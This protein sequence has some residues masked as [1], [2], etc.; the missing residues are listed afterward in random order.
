M[1]GV[2]G[3]VSTSLETPREFENVSNLSNLFASQGFGGNAT[4]VFG[5]S[6][7][8]FETSSLF[9]SG[10][11]LN[12]LFASNAMGTTNFPNVSTQGSGFGYNATNAFGEASSSLE[13]S[14]V[15]GSGSNS[16]NL[17]ASNALGTT[18]FPNVSTQWSAYGGTT[19]NV[20]R[21]ASSSLG[22]S[23]LFGNG[24]NLSN[25]FAPNTTKTTSLPSQGLIFGGSTTNVL[26]STS[27]SLG[28]SSLF[29]KDS[30][31]NHMFAPN[32][33]GS[34]ASPSFINQGS[35]IGGKSTGVFGVSSASS[36]SLT[37]G[38]QP[39]AFFGSS[40]TF[41]TTNVGN[42]GPFGSTTSRG[43]FGGIGDT[44][45][46]ACGPPAIVGF[47]SNNSSNA[48]AFMPLRNAL[49]SHVTGSNFGQTSNALGIMPAN[50]FSTSSSVAS[51]SLLAVLINVK[52]QV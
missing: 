2:F 22:T 29:G 42:D 52:S 28:M 4:N 1:A 17:F 30:N 44:S 38:R 49:A 36:P 37:I 20:F 9:G 21:E 51:P 13:T 41:G 10:S 45:A 40:S 33:T 16:S 39:T 31:S 15:F 7:S 8:P 12:N 43:A 47:T 14:S 35:F 6:L 27:S 46:R 25:V 48:A 18:N 32:I 11:N 34:T 19:T 3:Q 24:S 26:G 5:A 50:P 23:S